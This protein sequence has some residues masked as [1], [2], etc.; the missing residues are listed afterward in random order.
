MKKKKIG[1]I[2]CISLLSAILMILLGLYGSGVWFYS[3][4]FFPGSYVNDMEVSKYT[5]ED[6]VKDMNSYELIVQERLGDQSQEESM[7]LG[8][9][10]GLILSEPDLIET[11]IENQNPYLWLF[12]KEN[13]YSVEEM[14]SVDESILKQAIYK[15][16]GLSEETMV[17]PEDAYISD[18][19]SGTGYQMV[20]E[21][22][23]NELIY[24]KTFET[25]KNAVIE[26][27]SK[28][29]LD[30]LDCYEKPQITKEDVHLNTL[31]EQLNHYTS[32]NIQY[33][34]G[35][36][37][38]VLDGDTIHGWLTINGDEVHL[39]EESVREFVVSL[40]KKYDTIF[41]NRTFMTSYGKEVTISKGDYGWWMNYEKE[42]EELYAMIDAG[43]SGERTPVYYQTAAAYG[44]QDYGTTYVEIN[45]TAQHLFLYKDGEMILESDFVSGN[46]SKKNGTNVGIFPLTYKQMDAMLVGADY[47]TPVTYWMPFD[48]NIGMH[49]A[50]WRNQFGAK[51]YKTG[52]SHGCV[53]LPYLVA[54]EIFANIQKGTAVICY[55][56]KETESKTVT[57]QGPEEIAQSVIDAIDRIG[58]VT[59]NSNKKIERARLLYKEINATARRYV[60]NY[61]VLVEAEEQIKALK[62]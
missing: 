56:L 61:N 48:G 34:F 46:T 44:S 51:L 32:V 21:V 50:T 23:G 28:I 9:E 33:Q 41:R 13:H 26:L 58:T 15:L 24:D 40:R 25:I 17:K 39:S 54:Q 18:Y 47:K 27:Q 35:D 60:T 31:L 20:E 7:F 37:M 5:A 43:E 1:K 57:K 3:S 49:D 16:K 59:K 38:V 6:F 12:Q 52:G 2:I 30:E 8:S 19:I 11:L 29:N 45:L 22:Y 10:I 42:I 36:D 62:K 4:H 53:N 14:F 55:E